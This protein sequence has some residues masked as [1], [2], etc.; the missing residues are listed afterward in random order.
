MVGDKGRVIASDILPMDSLDNVDFIQGDFT[1]DAVFQQLLDLLAG[2][3]PDLIISDIAPNISGVAAADQ[4]SSMYLVEL[5]LDMVRQVLKPNGTF[6]AKVFQG[7]GSDEFL[8]DVRTS[9]EKMVIRKPEASRP[10]SREV[11]LVG[12]GFKG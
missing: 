9:F 11:Y 1:D 3:Q 6:V 12:K 2:R 7:E 4:A 5:V 8:K 10:R